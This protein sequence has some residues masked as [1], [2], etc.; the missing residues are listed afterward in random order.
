MIFSSAVRRAKASVNNRILDGFPTHA[1]WALC[2]T[3]TEPVLFEGHIEGQIVPPHGW[4]NLDFG[5]G[6]V[7]EADDMGLTYVRA[8]RFMPRSPWARCGVSCGDS[9]AHNFAGTR[10]WRR[11]IKIGFP[12][13]HMRWKSCACIYIEYEGY[14]FDLLLGGD[15]SIFTWSP[16]THNRFVVSSQI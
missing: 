10:R 16:V 7:F 14:R 12:I 6:P 4:H 13:G 15:G 11:H 8:L 5:R 2:T 3:S 1:A 9:D